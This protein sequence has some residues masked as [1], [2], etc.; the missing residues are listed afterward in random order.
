MIADHT[1]FIASVCLTLISNLVTFV[2]LKENFFGKFEQCR[3]DDDQGGG[4]GADDV[5]DDKDGGGEDDDDDED[6]NVRMHFEKL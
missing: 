5:I 4:N 1:T 3:F 6:G 2:L